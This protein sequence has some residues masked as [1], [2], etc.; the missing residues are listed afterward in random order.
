ME[1]LVRMPEFMAFLAARQP[2]TATGLTNEFHA[3]AYALRTARDEVLNRLRILRSLGVV[4]SVAGTKYGLTH[5][6]EV[7][8]AQMSHFLSTSQ[9]IPTTDETRLDAST[10][11]DIGWLD[12]V[13]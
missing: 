9:I 2:C 3:S 1:R 7:E 13:L 6:G 11:A 10:D 12:A 5:L 8:A 4:A